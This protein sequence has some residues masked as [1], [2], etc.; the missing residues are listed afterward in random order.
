M[1]FRGGSVLTSLSERLR[2]GGRWVLGHKIFAIAVLLILTGLA[3]WIFVGTRYEGGGDRARAIQ[4][5]LDDRWTAG[6]SSLGEAA[7]GAAEDVP[8]GPKPPKPPAWGE[9]VARMSTDR[10]GLTWYVV[11]GVDAGDIASAP[12]HYPG[13]ALPGAKGNFAVA[14]HREHNLFWDLDLMR[15][16]DIITVET[17]LHT[18]RYQVT[19]NPII[20]LPNAWSEVSPTPPGFAAGSK[21]LTLTTCE[22]KWDNKHRMIVH[23]KLIST[24]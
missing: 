10:L 2:S 5:E 7:A 23:A 1:Y 18:Y 20:T 17:K 11:E 13:T 22:P 14:G 3:M 6:G 16:G 24:T 19:G 8:G 9:I 15:Q 4:E 12:G 21:L